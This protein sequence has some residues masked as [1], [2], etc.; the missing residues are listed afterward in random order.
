MTIAISKITRAGQITLP[1]KIRTSRAFAQSTAVTFEERGSEVVVRPL[2]AEANHPND[3]W[4][5]VVHTMQ[6]WLD[7]V[8]DDLIELPKDL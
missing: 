6:D 7:P 2:K 5:I 1:K 3:H 4:P 8:N